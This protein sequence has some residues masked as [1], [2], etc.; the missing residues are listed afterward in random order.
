MIIE[1]KWFVG[2]FKPPDWW[3]TNLLT[4]V[5]IDKLPLSLEANTGDP[6]SI[7]TS[8]MLIDTI[9]HHGV[10]GEPV[11]R[12]QLSHGALFFYYIL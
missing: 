6:I 11:Q 9:W 4:G 12:R 7:G 5:H 1:Y 2:V 3:E 10:R 8:P